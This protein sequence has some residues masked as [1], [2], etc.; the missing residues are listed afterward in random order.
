MVGGKHP[1][2]ERIEAPCQRQTYQRRH[3]QAR[4]VTRIRMVNAVH[5]EM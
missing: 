4:G 2:K 1:L 5:E 3:N